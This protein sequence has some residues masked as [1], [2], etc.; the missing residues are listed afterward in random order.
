MASDVELDNFSSCSRKRPD[1]F[2]S[3][4]PFDAAPPGWRAG[5]ESVLRRD[6]SRLVF[7]AKKEG[8]DEP[9]ESRLL[10]ANEE[11]AS[12]LQEASA[13]PNGAISSQRPSISEILICAVRCAAK[14]YI[15]LAE[16]GDLALVDELTGLYNRRGFMAIAERQLKVGRR[17]G[18][19]MLLFFMALDDL[20]QLNDSYGHSQAHHALNRPSHALDIT[21]PHY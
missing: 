1:H 11:F 12:L 7:R 17:S 2:R 15:L 5:V 4:R 10:E 21:F 13:L 3:S 14:Q 16:L 20:K 18:K 9:F 6:V 19:G 8:I